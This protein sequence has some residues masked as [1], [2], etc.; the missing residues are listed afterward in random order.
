MLGPT[1]AGLAL[2]LYGADQAA[3]FVLGFAPPGQHSSRAC[4]C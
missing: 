2:F 1:F 4:R 3:Y